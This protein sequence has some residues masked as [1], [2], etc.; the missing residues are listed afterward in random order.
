VIERIWNQML[1]NAFG[2]VTMSNGTLVRGAALAAL[3]MLLGLSA[4]AQAQTAQP[5]AFTHK[6]ARTTVTTPQV[7]AELLAY[8]PQGVQAGQPLWLGLSLKH[9]PQ[10]HTYWKNSG[11]SGQPTQLEWQLPKGLQAGDIAWPTP[12]TIPIGPLANYGY[13]DEV[14]LPVP[15]TVAA[16][17]KPNAQGG[18]V[19]IG[20][21]ARWLVCR[22]ECIPEE[23]EF[24][25]RLPARGSVATAGAAF[26]KA[27]AAS[28]KAFT[29]SATSVIVVKDGALHL[30]VDKL[31][32]A[33]KGQTL[34]LYPETPEITA[35]AAPIQQSWQG[36]V[37]QARV[38]LTP[39]RAGDPAH[40]PVVLATPNNA[41]ALAVS[42]PIQGVWPAK[43][44]PAAL[45][46]N[47]PAPV[48]PSADAM[49][50]GFV[51]ALL[52]AGLG[53]L[54]LNLMPCVFPILAIKV[55]QLAKPEQTRSGRQQQA[56]AYTLGVLAS[57]LALGGL[58]LALRAAGEG[59]GWGFQLQNPW[60]VMALAAL[61][62]VVAVNLLGGFEVGQWLPSRWAGAGME[63]TH[64]LVSALLTGVLTVAVA[65]PCSA[66][67]MGAAMGMAITLPAWQALMIFA[68]LGLGLAL[69]FLLV[70]WVPQVASC[71]PR[72]GAWMQGFRQLLAYPMMATVV[73]LVWV[74]GQQNGLDAAAAL[75]VLLV[76]LAMLLWA[77]NGYRQVAFLDKA[78]RWHRV[79][80]GAV[81]LVAAVAGAAL[82]PVAARPG[83]DGH[84]DVGA[85]LP[86]TAL[87]AASSSPN[88]S[89]WQA[90]SRQRVDYALASGQPVFVD[91]TAAWCVTC[92]V[93]KK[94]TL[95]H[96]DVLA[97]LAQNNVVL[98]RADWT[99]P[100]AEIAQSI[101]S[102]GRS[103]VPVYALYWPGQPV[104]LLPEL[105]TPGGVIEAVGKQ[106]GRAAGS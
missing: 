68:A 19:V 51:L 7:A 106:S 46:Q 58:M 101:A 69:P 92:Q 20:L 77:S 23:G 89:Q 73:W 80:L 60:V 96:P 37:W 13:E 65:S 93:N 28:P 21:K 22:L 95:N 103:G 78:T 94:T 99:R 48:V 90:W 67:F 79:G 10:W 38:A 6:A 61:F 43:K 15:V 88:A 25:L 100:N 49:G 53:G 35:P 2:T 50:W 59:V 3:T 14:L 1:R 33:W 30:T 32:A 76:V 55:L 42:L 5:F 72:P 39:Y 17:Y 66:P 16:D 41:Q 29:A 9:Q 24:E 62:V 64:P 44:E 57:M 86:G 75:L 74:L 54:L 104:Q 4:L 36:Q 31:P 87:Q 45:V 8:A 71:L 105:L 26:E 47:L 34:S 52:G 12:K 97:A 102:L 81:V 11:D 98:L 91:Y 27:F 84:L 40:L 82:G 63:A 56:L 70:G 18:E 85:N 83:A